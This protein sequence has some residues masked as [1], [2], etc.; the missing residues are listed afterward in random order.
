MSRYWQHTHQ[1]QELQQQNITPL[2]IE[3]VCSAILVLYSL[4]KVDIKLSAGSKIEMTVKISPKQ[5]VPH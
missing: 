5:H 1:K 3:P 2:T 4:S